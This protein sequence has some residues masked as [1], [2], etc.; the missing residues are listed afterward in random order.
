MRI[1]I[2]AQLQPT[3][4]WGGVEQFVLGL[5]HALGRL[6]DG[7]EEY[8][9]VGHWEN[10][11]WLKP[12][13]GPN[14][15][16]VKAPPPNTLEPVKQR[17]GPL[18]APARRFLR[19][20]R[21]LTR[22]VPG[23]P[24]NVALEPNRFYESLG[25]A[26]VHF[27]FQIFSYCRLPIIYN[28]HDLQHLHYPQFFSRE[29]VAARESTYSVACRIAQAVVT[30]AKWVKDDIGRQYGVASE[31]IFAIPMGAPT[32]LYDDITA[33]LLA[34]VKAKFHLAQ[35]FAF[36]PAQTWQHKNHLRLLDA[37]AA[38]R[39]D[40]GISLPLVCT[41]KLNEHWP[42]IKARIRALGLQSH[43]QF[44]GFIEPNDLRALYHLAQ[45]V[46]H[47]S[48][49]E[50]GGLPIL[51]AFREGAPVA[52]ANVTSLPEYAGNAALYF[53]PTSVTSIADA[54][55]RMTTDAALRESLC[56]RGAVRVRE[57]T[58][59]RTARMY[60]ALYRQIAGQRLSDSERDLLANA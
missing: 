20:W 43:V 51:E 45:F 23:S 5:V 50:G 55:K 39:D 15:E 3:G 48:L 41:G 42:K 38:L 37:L 56:A 9:I 28:P 25:V 52:C 27:P 36:Y 1:A 22:R 18:R 54:A 46:I 11:D 7:A 35:T 33:P 12:H 34:E 58:W 44:L 30:D 21:R 14:Q 31:K 26:L 19:R 32:E 53:D 47:P 6:D 59:E 8:V 24:A 40:A 2:D 16:L 13:L 10:A 57:F 4:H 49:F 17:L 29:D 60:R